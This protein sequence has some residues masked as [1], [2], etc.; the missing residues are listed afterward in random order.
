MER[1]GGLESHRVM[2]GRFGR[3]RRR[4]DASG[5][6]AVIEPRWLERVAAGL[7]P[8]EALEQLQWSDVP[9]SFAL[10]GAGSTADGGRALVAVSPRSGGDALLAALVAASREA[11]SGTGV[12]A[13]SPAW[14]AVSRRRLSW[15]AGLAEPIHALA[16]ADEAGAAPLAGEPAPPRPLACGQVAAGVA[17]PGARALLRRAAAALTGLAA[18]HGGAL[19][20]AGDGLEL[21]VLTRA[22]AALRAEGDRVVL[23]TIL[24]SRSSATL[25][26]ATLPDA[27]DRLE[28]LVRKR[29]NDR[30]VREGEEGLRERLLVPLAAAA[31]LRDAVRWPGAGALQAVDLAAVAADGTPALGAV[32]ERISLPV[33]AEILDAVGGLEPILPV[34]L[35]D[36]GAPVLLTQR[37]RLVLAFREIDAACTDALAHLALEA[38]AFEIS[39]EGER[40]RA[41]P[42]GAG[43]AP[44]TPREP[45]AQE[46]VEA[47]PTAAAEA[48]ETEG[49]REGAGRNR[50]RR[51]RG[52]RRPGSREQAAAGE[53]GPDGADLTGG[54]EELEE[55]GAPERRF[56]EVSLFDLDEEPSGGEAGPSRRRRR[57][58]RGRG[59]GRQGDSSSEEEGETSAEAVAESSSGRGRA[60]P[61]GR[62]SRK[63]G[64]S[65][66]GAA[67]RS[68]EE[69]GE[70]E[71]GEDDEEILQLSPDAPDVEDLE[72]PAY[73]DEEEGE[74]E[75]ELDRIRLERERRRRARNAALGVASAAP[76]SSKA[77][78]LRDLGPEEITLPRG[79]AA[80]LAHADRDSI[81]AALLLARDLRQVEGIWV[82]PQEDLMTF[83]R[84][85]AVDLR[86]GAP[87]YVIGFS[88]K[89]ARDA[90]QAASLYRGRLVWFD[91]HEWA[92]EDVGAL[93]EAL[94]PGFARIEPESGSALSGI[95]SVC[96]RRSRFSDKLVDLVTGRFTAHDFERWG[97]LWW[98]RLGELAKR[99]GEHRAD[100]ESL[101][102]G[103]P[104]D[105][106]R[107]ARSAET[108][109]PPAE[110]DFVSSRDFRL[111]HFGGLGLVVVEVPAELDLYLASRIARERYGVA[112]SI[113]RV[114]GQEV[115]VL[116]GDDASGRRSID[117]GAMVEH[118]AQKFEWCEGLGDADHV[119]RLRVRGPADQAERVDELIAEIGMGRSILEG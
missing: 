92:P 43:E 42:L 13:V 117:V 119:A 63:G 47:L 31:G 45:A 109:P 15:T 23:E 77:A 26:E 55:P 67:S 112:L 22:L 40:L 102:S 64:P 8:V 106:A 50:R 111:V 115:W 88:A 90:I 59:R 68:F 70:G 28:G 66:G 51:R 41:R 33:L 94:G 100:L 85:V 29:L 78:P 118:L 1:A 6:K 39:A 9:D 76:E 83:F 79:R 46:V 18:K 24:P 38:T 97:R 104:S 2:R 110:L 62:G 21:V 116:A 53:D 69:D 75:S 58:G 20:V 84:G 37:P 105:L 54:E 17:S 56:E 81:A 74:P 25:S 16:A 98:W 87:I 72:V 7:V 114:E 34:V 99:T 60:R 91:H 12:W 113:G 73:E 27:L 103:R 5:T 11:G 4:D 19:R 65:K 96:N 108:P 48:S 52:R 10:V 107:E 95:L 71:I 32:R 101:L 82:Y 44:P 89:P 36:A 14:N 57:R 3:R 93:R 61:K 35:A 49:P 80:I 30:E 86:E